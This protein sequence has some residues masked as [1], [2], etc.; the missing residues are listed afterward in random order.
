M[1][2]P[3]LIVGTVMGVGSVGGKVGAP[4]PGGVTLEEPS[5]DGV[6]VG[7]GERGGR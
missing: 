3:G 2:T 5:G 1:L 6:G 7:S 4:V